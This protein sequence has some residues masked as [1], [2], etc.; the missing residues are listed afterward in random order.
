[1]P[2]VTQLAAAPTAGAG[3]RDHPGALDIGADVRGVRRAKAA[4]IR[5]A[6]DMRAAEWDDETIEI[7][8]AFSRLPDHHRRRIMTALALPD[9]ERAAALPL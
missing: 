1:M 2:F 8:D 6:A 7:A 4:E 9:A 5:T 3:A